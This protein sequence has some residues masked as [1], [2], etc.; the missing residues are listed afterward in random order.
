M[1]HSRRLSHA[2]VVAAVVITLLATPACIRGVTAGGRCRTTDWG[3]G[4]GWVM[5]C[6]RG[7]WVRKAPVADVA[8]ALTTR[9][10]RGRTLSGPTIRVAVAGDS[11]GGTIA[12][13]AQ[14]FAATHPGDLEVLDLTM[15]NCTI[16][17]VAQIRHFLGERGQ[18]M[19]KCALWT[20]DAP[21][22]VEQFRPDVVVVFVAMM[23][24]ADQRPSPSDP[25]HNV[26][27]PEWADNQLA[28]F[29]RYQDALAST[30][31]DVL[32]ASVPYMRFRSTSLPW[33]SHAPERTDALNGLLLR[34]DA[35]RP[36]ATVVNFAARLNRPGRVID[37]AV[38]PDGIH[39]SDVAA[40]EHVA[41]WLVPLLDSRRR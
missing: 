13:A 41:N 2:L 30:G 18:S 28:A 3:E 23:E 33:V 4:R 20:I 24:Q 11:T 22:R 9:V 7:R 35:E 12:R 34:L 36:D 25:W 39:L 10:P 17:F 27:Q 6:E 19:D 37:F 32:W 40:D 5:R 1:S 8:R 14:R 16:T 26:L 15:D 38:R 31:A 29:R 21:R